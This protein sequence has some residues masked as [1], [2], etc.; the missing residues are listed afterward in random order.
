[1][2]GAQI[3]QELERRKGTRPSPGTVYPVLKDLKDKDLISDKNKKYFLTSKGCKELEFHIK[4]FFKTF[5]DL[6][7]MK[8]WCKKRAGC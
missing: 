4:T 8:S 5:Y 6:D 7:Q 1:M 3:A 2:T